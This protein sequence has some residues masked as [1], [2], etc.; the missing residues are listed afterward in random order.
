MDPQIIAFFL[1]AAV[2]TITPGSDTL[3]VIKNSLRGGVSDGWSTTAG[4]C[5]GL[6]VHA[7]ASALGISVILAQSAVAFHAVKRHPD[8]SRPKRH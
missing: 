8:L 6:F 7:L 5:S 3:L 4:I 2:L 1:V